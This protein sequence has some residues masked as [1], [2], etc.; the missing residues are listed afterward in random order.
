[1]AVMSEFLDRGYNVAVPE[2]DIGDDLFVVRDSNGEYWRIQVKTSKTTRTAKGTSALYNLRLAQLAEP[3][4][5]ETWYVFVQRSDAGWGDFMLIR[6]PKLYD[7]HEALQMGSRN[8]EGYVIRNVNREGDRTTCSG[9][10]LTHH[11]NDWSA[12][13]PVPH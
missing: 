12:W 10:D 6:Q 2:V 11:V 4:V 8:R 1:M 13:P 5:P 7:Y 9:V 3:T